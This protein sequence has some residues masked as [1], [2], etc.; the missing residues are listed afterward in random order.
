MN[1]ALSFAMILVVK[2]RNIQDVLVKRQEALNF[3]ASWLLPMLGLLAALAN[4]SYE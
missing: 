3:G 4:P 2:V 1:L